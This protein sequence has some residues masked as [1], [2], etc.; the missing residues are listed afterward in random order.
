MDK[1]ILEKTNGIDYALLVKEVLRDLRGKKSQGQINNRFGF[2]YNKVAKWENGELSISWTEFLQYA[3]PPEEDENKRI[4]HYLSYYLGYSGSAKELTELLKHLIAKLPLEQVALTIN[5]SKATLY[6]WLKGETEPSLDYIFKILFLVDNNFLKFISTFS[7]PN[8]LSALEGFRN[9]EKS[10]DVFR[11]YPLIGAIL[12]VLELEQY[13]KMPEHV[14]GFIASKLNITQAEESFLLTLMMEHQLIDF[15]D[16]K[17]VCLSKAFYVSGNKQA[18]LKTKLFWQ[19]KSRE[20]LNRV[21]HEPGPGEG[22][23][24]WGYNVFASNAKTR[25]LIR[26][27]IKGFYGEVMGIVSSEINKEDITDV[28]LFSVGLQSVIEEANN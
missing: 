12:R 3:T 26:E 27:R 1:K 9:Q 13:G 21:Y 6:R 25:L 16:Q 14:E 15:K 24:L 28:I 2:D 18:Q 17:Y 19:D 8:N 7:D 23:H 22:D 4:T 5:C 20:I 11:N 10:K